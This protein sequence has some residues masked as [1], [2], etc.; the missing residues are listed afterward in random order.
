MLII[1]YKQPYEIIHTVFL[2]IGIKLLVVFVKHYSDIFEIDRLYIYRGGRSDTRSDSDRVFRIFGCFRFL[3]ISYRS[4]SGTFVF[5]V[6]FR[7]F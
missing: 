2:K 3:G 7:Y 6:G 4:R 5:W 1:F